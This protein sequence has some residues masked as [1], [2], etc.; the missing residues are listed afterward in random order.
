M[1]RIVAGTAGGRSLRVPAKGTRPTSEKVREALFSRLDHYGV[2]A[3]AR[4]LDLY[5][6]SGAL[7]LEAASRGAAAV[8]LVDV[9]RQATDV[10]RR[11][12]A[13]LGLGDVTVLTDRAERVAAAT[14]AAPWDLVLI[15]PPYDVP[16]DVVDGL[17]DA[18]AVEGRLSEGA[19]VV[20]ERS[21]RSAAPRWPADWELL[22]HRDYGETSVWIAGPVV[23]EPA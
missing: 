2:V 20:V 18:L 13:D 22:A 7:G 10:C 11:N 21:K 19:V 9:S 14:P 1:T 6:G 23:D 5:A 8:T 15:D 16:D 3:E 4:V 17:L 12:A